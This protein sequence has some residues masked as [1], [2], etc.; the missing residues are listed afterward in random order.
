MKKIKRFKFLVLN[1]KEKR[2]K[3]H[4]WY[5]VQSLPQS[6]SR[7]VFISQ[8]FPLGRVGQH[9]LSV[10]L[11]VRIVP[12]KV[13]RRFWEERV[14]LHT[15]AAELPSY[16]Q[17]KCRSTNKHGVLSAF[18]CMTGLGSTSRTVRPTVTEATFTF[19]HW[20][21]FFSRNTWMRCKAR[22]RYGVFSHGLKQ[23]YW[24]IHFASLV[25][26]SHKNRVA[27]VDSVCLHSYWPP[28]KTSGNSTKA[29]HKGSKEDL[30]KGSGGIWEV[31]K[32][33][34][35]HPT[36]PLVQQQERQG[37]IAPESRRKTMG[38]GRKMVIRVIRVHWDKHNDFRW[39]LT[40]K[41][42]PYAWQ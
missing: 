7:E 38:N 39:S 28:T 42:T 5:F 8:N 21:F 36:A 23:S 37:I 13:P 2:E 17:W 16:G 27:C 4:I 19:K 33:E 3:A 40:I 29:S 11:Q 22:P 6:E 34:T 32:W 30:W 41:G 10:Y 14:H 15:V 20:V 12:L 18:S 9:C 26:S 31:T 24:D 35:T 25:W 1:P